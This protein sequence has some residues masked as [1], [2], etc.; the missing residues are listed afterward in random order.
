[1]PKMFQKTLLLCAEKYSLFNSFTKILN[2]ISDETKGF[3]IRKKL[4]HFVLQSQ[5]QM[6]RFPHK[7]RDRWE[8][9][10]LGT[11]NSEI[12]TEIKTYKPGLV[13]V[14]NSEYLIPET[15]VEIKKNARLVFFMGDSPFFTPMNPYYLSCLTYADLVLCPDTFWISQMSMLGIKN[16]AY[17]IP[18]I[19][20]SSYYIIED[21]NIPGYIEET[22]IFYSGSCY[23]N[24]WGYKKALLMN[25]FTGMNFKLFGNRSW[26]KWFAF[27]P[28]LQQHYTETKFISS[29]H[30]NMMMNRAKVMPVDGNPAIL[31][32]FHL[33]LFEA[34]GSGVL[35][36]VESRKDVEDVLLGNSDV[37]VPMIR[38]YND[39]GFMAEYYI[40][41][42]NERKDIINALKSYILDYYSATRNGERLK[43]LLDK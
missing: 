7:I 24:S 1:M 9:I 32:G 5:S 34:L 8:N 41:N 27:F 12:I 4:N 15:C 25:Q 16:I 10:V 35:P 26:K 17:F 22:D 33:R 28:E 38:D 20:T 21:Q 2:E 13:F 31:N 6:F 14:Y 11:A 23:N 19:D 42:E 40:R 36:L 18:G 3:D 37:I 29:E 39:A 30:L 43:E